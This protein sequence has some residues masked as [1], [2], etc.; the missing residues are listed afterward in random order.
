MIIRNAAL[1]VNA[2]LAQAALRDSAV[3]D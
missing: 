3:G 2:P 1:A